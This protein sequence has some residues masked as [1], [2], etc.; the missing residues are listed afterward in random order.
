[1]IFSRFCH[2]SLLLPDGRVFIYG[3]YYYDEIFKISKYSY[4]AEFYNPDTN[5][6]TSG[7]NMINNIMDGTGIGDNYA[8][9]IDEEKQY[10]CIFTLSGV[11]LYDLKNDKIY[12]IDAIHYDYKT[13]KFI[14][15][16]TITGF[17]DKALEK[18]LMEKMKKHP[19]FLC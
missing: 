18:D 3:G 7:P 6:F 16:N 13:D 9:F 17:E 4:R 5:A 1:M 10:L 15:T 8:W 11:N 12:A 14:G 2:S 19:V